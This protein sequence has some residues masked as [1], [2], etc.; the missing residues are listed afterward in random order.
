[1]AVADKAPLVL[2]SLL[3]CIVSYGEASSGGGAKQC[4]HPGCWG[5]GDCL[6][7]GV[8]RCDG[9]YG[10]PACR[11][12]VDDFC[13]EQC[14][15]HGECLEDGTCACREGFTGAACDVRTDEH[16]A[17][18]PNLCS[19]H[20][21]CEG[22]SGC[23]CDAGF[24]GADCARAE[25]VAVSAG[26]PYACSGHGRCHVDGTCQCF[27][28]FAGDGCERL[29]GGAGC[30]AGCSGHGWCEPNGACRCAAGFG[31]AACDRVIPVAACAD[32]CSGHGR[33]VGHVRTTTSV[34]ADGGSL[35]TGTASLQMEARCE[36]TPA[37]H[38][39]W[40][41][42]SCAVLQVPQ[43]CE[44]GCSGHGTCVPIPG[45]PTH[46][47]CACTSGFGG[48]DCSVARPC[49]GRCSGRGDCVNGKCE[50]ARGWQG[51]ACEAPRC[52]AD[53][54]GHGT[55]RRPPSEPSDAIGAEANGRGAMGVCL[56]A[57][58]WSGLAC[59]AWQPH[60]PNGCSGRGQCIDGRCQCAAGYVGD[61]CGELEGAA[62][63]SSLS[64]A[65]GDGSC[66]AMLCNG[67]GTCQRGP[68]AAG[69]LVC[70]C[71]DGYGGPRCEQVGAP[72]AM[73]I[74]SGA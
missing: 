50:C 7:S 2:A 64:L 73:P 17:G 23:V 60:C 51:A 27:A 46:G 32:N 12:A 48:E 14:S 39:S 55:C 8:C 54:S 24:V 30:P 15:G 22:A 31:G 37:V 62:P 29:T 36:C 41:G 13:P 18:C 40:S 3:V 56:C 74:E 20:G 70:A 47:R 6:D 38:Y 19:G 1:M 4:P 28:G 63:S 67:H 33:C 10:G 68:R 34:S 57:A 45:R 44:H 9:G 26:C 43:G 49:P 53:C 11:L 35:G 42:P 72:R 66:G 21:R 25:L 69:T 61:G 65:L 71:F 52:P 16:S 59:D 58:G 5:R